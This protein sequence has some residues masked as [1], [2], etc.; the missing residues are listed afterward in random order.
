M[1]SRLCINGHVI[2]ISILTYP[3][4]ATEPLQA[5]CRC[6]PHLS[7]IN[8]DITS[9]TS[10][11]ALSEA[12]VLR[13]LRSRGQAACLMAGSR[14]KTT[15][16]S[17]P[18]WIRWWWSERGFLMLYGKPLEEP[19]VKWWEDGWPDAV[20]P[21]SWDLNISFYQAF[22]VWWR[23]AFLCGRGP[24]SLCSGNGKRSRHNSRWSSGF[25]QMDPNGWLDV[26][27]C[28]SSAGWNYVLDRSDFRRVNQMV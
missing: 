21:D 9:H 11:L 7:Y 23:P 25:T 18:F 4:L 22:P 12:E 20:K 1:W 19:R 2:P 13:V 28:V 16:R 6:H 24:S 15:Y 26:S 5:P 10:A 17:A 27:A 3:L 14:E 8:S